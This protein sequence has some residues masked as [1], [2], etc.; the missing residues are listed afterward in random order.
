MPPILRS[1]RSGS[2]WCMRE[3]PGEAE[4][5]RPTSARRVELMDVT[6]HDLDIADA[7]NGDDGPGALDRGLAEIDP[8]DRP[9]R[10]RK[11][12][13]HRQAAQWAAA[14]L[15]RSP[16]RDVPDAADR[17]AG[18]LGLYL[19]H[20]QEPAKVPVAAVKDVVPDSAQVL[21]R[22]I[23]PPPVVDWRPP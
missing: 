15:D 1:V 20:A 11:L 14:A 10:A 4:I 13:Q 3:G 9:G 19:G 21:T 22:A 2:A 8:D 18:R 23:R 17:R 12:G 5:E 16:A 7:Q 6:G